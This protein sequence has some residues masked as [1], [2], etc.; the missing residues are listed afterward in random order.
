LAVRQVFA[1]RSDMQI[2]SMP[3]VADVAGDALPEFV[4]T[5]DLGLV[6]ILDADGSPIDGYPRKMLPDDIAAQM[7]VA[8]LDDD[9]STREVVAV[10]E[11]SISVVAPPAGN[12]LLSAWTHD[13]GDAGRTRFAVSPADQQGSRDRLLAIEPSFQA[14]PNPSRGGWVRLRFTSRSV[15]PFDIR[16]YNLEGEQVFNRMGNTVSGPQEVEWNVD[17]MA[18]GVY[19]CRF[20]SVAAG[21][22]S[23]LIEP[24]TVVR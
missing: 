24:I 21:V 3:V 14:Y 10:S 8:D 17:G 23:P 2:V 1:I 12:A 7:L 4:F 9:P 20:H 13:R 16:I 19:L 15:G 6:Y 5:T 11:V 18:S 22:S